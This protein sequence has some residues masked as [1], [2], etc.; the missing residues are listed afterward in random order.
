MDILLIIIC[1]SLKLS[2]K[3]MRISKITA[4][5]SFCWLVIEFFC[6]GQPLQ[7][8]DSI[9]VALSLGIRVVAKSQVRLGLYLKVQLEKFTLKKLIK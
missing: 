4:S 8:K 5:S 3:N 2:K 6:N 9:M 1:C 7:I